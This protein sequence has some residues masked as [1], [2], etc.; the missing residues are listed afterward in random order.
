MALSEE[1][2]KAIITYR[3]EKAKQT[4]V[5]AE[6]NAALKHWNLVANRL[7]YAAFHAAS[8][9]LISRGLSAKTHNGTIRLLGKEFVNTGLLTIV[10]GSLYSRLYNMR[11]CGDYDDL[12]DWT[13][14][15]VTPL[16]RPTN[17]LLAK[18]ESLL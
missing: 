10:E 9:L 18:I 6:D 17:D 2:K 11:Q 12:F 1:E 3:M 5:E 8:A 4:F 15:D 14:D 7:Y 16:I 13:E